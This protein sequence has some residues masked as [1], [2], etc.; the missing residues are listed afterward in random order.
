M[1]SNWAVDRAERYGSRFSLLLSRLP[2]SRAPV[3]SPSRIVLKRM[4][5]RPMTDERRHGFEG[6]RDGIATG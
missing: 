3:E 6:A 5:L 4:T 1:P 2:P